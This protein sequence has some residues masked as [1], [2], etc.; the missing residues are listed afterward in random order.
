MG[1]YQDLYPRFLE[2]YEKP[3]QGLSRAYILAFKEIKY[4]DIE[5]LYNASLDLA[6]LR[7]FEGRIKQENNN[8]QRNIDLLRE[9]YTSVIEKVIGK[10]KNDEKLKGYLTLPLQSGKYLRFDNDSSNEISSIP[11]SE[12]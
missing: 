4:L 1:S 12:K 7:L 5:R 2:T 8:K 11:P 3:L 6:H 9:S 10:I